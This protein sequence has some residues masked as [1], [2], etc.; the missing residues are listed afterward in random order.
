MELFAACLAIAGLIGM[1][2]ACILIFYAGIH[3][4]RANDIYADVKRSISEFQVDAVSKHEQIQ[5]WILQT[6]IAVESSETKSAG[7]REFCAKGYLD[8]EKKVQKIEKAFDEL[9]NTTKF[10]N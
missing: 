1:V 2:G 4:S 7:V 3:L 9:N 5:D 6:N 10:L 8:M